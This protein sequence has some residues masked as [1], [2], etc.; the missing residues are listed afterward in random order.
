MYLS[1]CITVNHP[2]TPRRLTPF[3][4]PHIYQK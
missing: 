4:T 2:A 3:P 1:T